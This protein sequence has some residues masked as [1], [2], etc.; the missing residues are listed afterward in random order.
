MAYLL[1]FGFDMCGPT[2]LRIRYAKVI[3]NDFGLLVTRKIIDI[4]P[5]DRF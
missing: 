1:Q 2:G 5:K 3:C 4:P